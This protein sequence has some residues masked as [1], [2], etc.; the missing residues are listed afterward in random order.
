MTMQIDELLFDPELIPAAVQESVGNDIEIRPLAATD[1]ARGHFE[2]LTV[3]TDAPACSREEYKCLHWLLLHDCL[4]GEEVGQGGRIFHARKLIMQQLVAVGTVF[5]ER[6]FTRG[7]GVVGHIED[8]AVSKSM[9]G[10]K[11]G[12][13]LIKSLE[14]IARTQGCYKVILDCSTANIPFY[15]K[16]GRATATMA[17]LVLRTSVPSLR[18]ASAHR[19]QRAAT[20]HS[21]ARPF[22]ARSVAHAQQGMTNERKSSVQQSSDG[23]RVAIEWED[24]QRSALHK[25]W[26][27][28]IASNPPTVTYASV[29]PET[30]GEDAERGVLQWLNKVYGFCF[31]TGVPVTP[32]ATE[33]LIR[34]MSFIRE[35]HCDLAYSNQALPAHTDTAYFTDPA[36]LQ[37][38]HC[39]KDGEG[40]ETLLV[41]SFYAARELQARDPKAYETLSS[42]AVPFHA[43]GN[44][45]TL[46][47]PPISQPVLRH[48]HLGN[49]IQARWNNEDRCVLGEGWTPNEIRE[50]YRAARAFE[51]IVTSASTEYWSKLTPGTLVVIDNWRVMHGRAAFTGERRMCG[52]YVGADDWKSRRR[53]LSRQLYP[54][55]EGTWGVGCPTIATVGKYEDSRGYVQSA[56]SSR[57]TVRILGTRE[58]SPDGRL[59]FTAMTT[60]GELHLSVSLLLPAFSML[61]S[62]PFELKNVQLRV[63]IL[64][65]PLGPPDV[66]IVKLRAT[67]GAG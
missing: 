58:P 33:D 32:E 61:A 3:L 26:G 55:A 12:L 28:S 36:G 31:V 7:L 47:R 41:D 50:W 62:S 2:L 60:D 6:K 16:C 4:R 9:Q 8:I 46:L 57:V 38:F 65:A 63:Y 59:R 29:M 39:L 11:L 15:E 43:S 1:D 53:A 14:E 35:T 51:N 42:L 44:E 34:R 56:S 49:L 20:K 27:A 5:V 25:L 24:G 64:Y 45:G 18:L 23:Q 54:P 17:N 48:D 67:T 13:Y 40:G 37:I 30:A 52:A 66:M 19:V 21:L 22:S 10:R